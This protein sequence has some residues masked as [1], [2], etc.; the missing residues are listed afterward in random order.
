MLSFVPYFYSAH[1]LLG[2][3]PFELS[4]W[5]CFRLHNG[6]GS[7]LLHTLRGG[8][9]DPK[10][11]PWSEFARV[12]FAACIKKS[13][14]SQDKSPDYS[15]P[16]RRVP[17][18]G[19]KK[20]KEGKKSIFFPIELSQC[21]LPAFVPRSIVCACVC[22]CT[23][24]CSHSCYLKKCGPVVEVM[25]ESVKKAAERVSKKVSKSK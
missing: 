6:N 16:L 12:V 18:P 21:S 9:G 17:A 22:V 10:W 24:S 5:L 25:L 15:M 11:L 20:K 14:A 13:G 1:I 8:G 7:M 3:G 4:A 19:F 2:R 23:T